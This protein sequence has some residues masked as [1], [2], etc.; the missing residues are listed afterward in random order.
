MMRTGGIEKETIPCLGI[1]LRLWLSPQ[2][3]WLE[4]SARR[5]GLR[6]GSGLFLAGSAPHLELVERTAAL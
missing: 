1:A 6:M 2:S 5:V 4:F 3:L